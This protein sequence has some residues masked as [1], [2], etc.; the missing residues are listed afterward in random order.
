MSN[1]HKIIKSKNDNFN[2]NFQFIDSNRNK[3]TLAVDKIDFGLFDTPFGRALIMKNERGICG[4]AFAS[5]FGQKF[6][7]QDMKKRWP[8]TSFFENYKVVKQYTK[9]I[10]S[11]S[12]ELCLHL[13]GS[14][15]QFKVWEELLKIPKGHTKSY[16]EISAN[17]GL[18]KATR[19]VATAIGCNPISWLIPCHRVLRKSGTLGG[20]HWGLSIKEKL[21]SYEK[22]PF[23][24]NKNF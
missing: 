3:H 21:L 22:S 7:L 6:A 16:S 23:L 11:G 14:S 9:I 2:T 4:L 10:L 13:N 24:N 18:P 17:I 15:F 19:A 20:Y 5:E 12:G 8:N 1:L